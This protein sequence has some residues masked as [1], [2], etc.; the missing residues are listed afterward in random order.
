METRYR[1][2]CGEGSVRPKFTTGA[3]TG[4]GNR[5]TEGE[6]KGKERITEWVYQKFINMVKSKRF[7]ILNKNI[8]SYK[9][10]LKIK[11]YLP[12]SYLT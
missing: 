7:I 2:W 10:S 3:W 11:V 1:P 12:D 8:I 9:K 4:E 5:A 6:A